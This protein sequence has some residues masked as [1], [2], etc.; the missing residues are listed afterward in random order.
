[1]HGQGEN[2]SAICALWIT[3]GVLIHLK[4]VLTGGLRPMYVSSATLRMSQ[5]CKF[6]VTDSAVLRVLT[7]IFNPAAGMMP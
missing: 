6:F 1:M 4:N 5:H 3:G 7:Y 2:G